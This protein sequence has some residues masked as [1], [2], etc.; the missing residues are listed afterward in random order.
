MEQQEQ[1]RVSVRMPEAH[2]VALEAMAAE[3]DRT[4]SAEIRRMV[5]RYIEAGSQQEAV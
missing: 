4:I 3:E 2:A 5:R 1:V